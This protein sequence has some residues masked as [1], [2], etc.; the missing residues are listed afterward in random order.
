MAGAN[1]GA[2][3]AKIIRASPGQNVKAGVSSI[4][5]INLT[6]SYFPI[7]FI[8][9][10]QICWCAEHNMTHIS[11]LNAKGREILYIFFSDLHQERRWW[12]EIDCSWVYWYSP[13][14]VLILEYS[15]LNFGHYTLQ[16]VANRQQIW[17][18][19]CST[20]SPVAVTIREA[21]IKIQSELQLGADYYRVYV[22]GR[23][24]QTER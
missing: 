16:L 17:I 20:Q 18:F 23:R 8:V 14:L 4:Y 10:F 6:S 11:H 7:S 5:S 9:N 24:R 12:K 2:N 3:T 1:S 15:Y 13:V 21:K 19:K 22:A